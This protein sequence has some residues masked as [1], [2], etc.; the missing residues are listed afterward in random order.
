MRYRFLEKTARK[1]GIRKIVT[2]HHA[3]D[4]A[5]TFLI[6]WLQGAGLKGLGGMGLSRKAAGDL[7]I[8]RPLLLTRRAEI[9]R[10][11]RDHRIA[12][13]ED[14]TNRSDLFLRG[15]IR[16]LL[17]GIKKENPNLGVRTSTNSIFL[18]ADESFLDLI[19]REI[20]GRISERGRRRVRVGLIPYCSLPDAVRYRILQKIARGL[21]SDD[22]ALPA[23]AVLK[24][25]EILR[26]SGAPKHYDLP[27]GLGLNKRREWFEMFRKPWLI[28]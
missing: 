26:D 11:A 3:D 8:L 5:E 7:D 28:R 19:A 1:F 15:R 4:Q 14:P 13:R 20:F 9:G 10:Y 16:R 12:Y 25:D 24:A 27:S 23:E 17:A 21:R 2:A 22:Y 18:R 6:R